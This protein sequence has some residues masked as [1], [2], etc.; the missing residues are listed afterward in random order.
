M[1]G[2]TGWPSCREVPVTPQYSVICLDRFF[3]SI[4]I[5]VMQLGILKHQ[6]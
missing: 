6:V 4:G 3:E 1:R 2:F 5:L